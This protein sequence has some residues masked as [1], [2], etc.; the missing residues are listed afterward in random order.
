[1]TVTH[2]CHETLQFL[3]VWLHILL[4]EYCVVLHCI[5]CSA[6]TNM[7]L[8][9]ETRSVDVQYAETSYAYTYGKEAPDSCPFTEV[10][11]PSP[12]FS[13]SSL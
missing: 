2:Y 12:P 7:Q 3:L 13:L 5:M 9:N 8:L 10:S 11:I 1:M 6:N 4:N